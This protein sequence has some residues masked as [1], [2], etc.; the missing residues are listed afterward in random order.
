MALDPLPEATARRTKRHPDDPTL[1]ARMA[2][3]EV[4]LSPFYIHTS[5]II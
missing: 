1:A 2:R 4:G 5:I 3:G